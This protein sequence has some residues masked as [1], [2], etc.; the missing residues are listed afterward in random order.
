MTTRLLK[1]K[2]ASEIYGLA[3]WKIRS[4]IWNG[5]LPY[6]QDGRKMQVDTID[7]DKWI[8]DNKKIREY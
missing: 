7:L 1:I 3:V 4:L 2:E 6:I 8:D 5:Q